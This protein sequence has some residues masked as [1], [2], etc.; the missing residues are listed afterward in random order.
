MVLVLGLIVCVRS[1]IGLDIDLRLLIGLVWVGVRGATRTNLSTKLSTSRI[2]SRRSEF[3][4]YRHL[5]SC[6]APV[7]HRESIETAAIAGLK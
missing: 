7:P 5:V 4:G 3:T 1:L 2:S 6:I